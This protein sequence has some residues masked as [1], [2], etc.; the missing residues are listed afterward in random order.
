MQT[1]LN[2]CI[3]DRERLVF[4]TYLKT[5]GREQEIA[6]LEW[7]DCNWSQ[8]I[9]LGRIYHNPMA[10]QEETR[11]TQSGGIASKVGKRRS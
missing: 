3:S 9:H 8:G 11:S 2:A 1:V 5:G 10:I 6:F 7:I 4:D